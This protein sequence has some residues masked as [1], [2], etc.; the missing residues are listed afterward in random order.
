M[1]KHNTVKTIEKV[2]YYNKALLENMKMFATVIFHN[3]FGKIEMFFFI[4]I[5]NYA[6]GT[7]DFFYYNI[8]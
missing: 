6:F 5:Y 8:A 3:T 1:K 7:V 4:I 2:C